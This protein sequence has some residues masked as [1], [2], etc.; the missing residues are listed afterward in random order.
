MQT[1][2]RMNSDQ[3]DLTPQVRERLRELVQK[4]ERFFDR[5]TGVHVTIQGPSAK[6]QQGPFD[7]RITITVPRQEIVVSHQHADNLDTAMR[8][9]FDAAVR[10]LEDY[11]QRLRGDVKSHW[12]ELSA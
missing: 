6:H 9:A 2:P 10:Q 1:P 11:S 3:I 4:L 7:V 8:E 12:N 5:I